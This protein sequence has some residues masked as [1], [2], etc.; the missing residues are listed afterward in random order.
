VSRSST[1]LALVALSL[2]VAACGTEDAA[3][4]G[5]DPAP[6]CDADGPASRTASCVV[7]FEPGEGAGHGQDALPDIVLG[8]PRGGGVAQGSL[9]VLSLGRGGS[10]VV[11][12]GGG[13]IVDGPGPDLLVFENAFYVGGDPTHPFAELGEVSVSDDGET[14]STFPC[15]TDA[16]PFEGCA[17]WHAVL[18]SPDAGVSP[19]DPAVAGGDPFDL[20]D[21][22][23]A[24]A[25]FVHVRDLGEDTMAPFAGFD[26]DAVAIV[27]GP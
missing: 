16:Y 13:A 3:A 12:F 27:N 17:G 9:D 4:S 23:L 21:L 26:L 5:D 20:A 1:P 11:G 8:E 18:A 10:I 6:G 25:R 24:S 14:W 19:F 2:L 22:G 15:R 7:S